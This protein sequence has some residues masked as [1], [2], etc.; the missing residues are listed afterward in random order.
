ML[1]KLFSYIAKTDRLKDGLIKYLV[2]F[3]YN[4][5]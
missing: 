1:N 2:R 3:G 5:R 4:I